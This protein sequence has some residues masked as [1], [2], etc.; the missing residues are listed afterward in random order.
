MT[1]EVMKCVDG[2]LTLKLGLC[3]LLLPNERGTTPSATV[4][5]S[6]KNAYISLAKQA[7]TLQVP[8]KAKIK[9]C[10]RPKGPGRLLCVSSLPNASQVDAP[11]LGQCPA[12]TQKDA[13]QANNCHT[14]HAELLL[15]SLKWQSQ[16]TLPS[17][18]RLHI[19]DIFSLYLTTQYGAPWF[20]STH[21]MLARSWHAQ[22]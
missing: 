8:P 15:N 19:Q 10:L 6:K 12:G 4:N 3:A 11:Q 1:L 16:C 22:C 7:G 5:L 2:S 9:A 20:I 13:S 17:N 14:C 21:S 18:S